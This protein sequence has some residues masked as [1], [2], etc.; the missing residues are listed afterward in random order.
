MVARGA[1][2]CD[3][4]GRARCGEQ[5][6]DREQ[7][8]REDRE[9]RRRRARIECVGAAHG[10]QKQ[11]RSHPEERIDDES[12]SQVC[13]AAE[14]SPRLR[15]D[16]PPGRKGD[17]RPVDAQ[18]GEQATGQDGGDREPCSLTD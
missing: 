3:G 15:P 13:L 18:A 14:R 9:A 1:D 12:G 8:D 11:R 16:L 7:G 17:E 4:R 6:G 10:E 2:P 5:V